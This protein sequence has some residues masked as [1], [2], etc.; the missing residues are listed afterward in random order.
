MC[1]VLFRLGGSKDPLF[2]GFELSPLFLF[3]LHALLL[4]D[5]GLHPPL[6]GFRLGRDAGQCRFRLETPLFR[7]FRL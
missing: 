7:G 5:F 3:G 1:Q 4:R 6:L 2:L